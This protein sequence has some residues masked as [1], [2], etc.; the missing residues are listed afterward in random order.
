MMAGGGAN[1]HCKAYVSTKNHFSDMKDPDVSLGRYKRFMPIWTELRAADLVEP[2]KVFLLKD[3]PSY[4]VG[5][6]TT[7]T[8]WW[9]EPWSLINLSQAQVPCASGYGGLW[10]SGNLLYLTSSPGHNEMME[11]SLVD[12]IVRYV[13]NGGNLL[14]SACAGRQYIENQKE[15]WVLLKKFGFAPP[16]GEMM[17]NRPTITTPVKS[18]MFNAESKPFTLRDFWIVKPPEG[19][20]TTAFFEGNQQRA[21]ITWKKFGK[22]K[23]AILWAQTIVPPLFS[24]ENGRYAFLSDVA[25]W[26]GVQPFAE[27][28]DNRLWTNLLKTK[29]GKKF[30]GL[31]HVGSWQNAPSAPVEGYV[32]WLKLPQGKYRVTELISGKELGEWTAD[33]LGKEGISVKMVPKSVAIYRMI[34]I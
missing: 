25:K 1:A 31:V 21:A 24:P 30:Y 4:L 27:V 5:A 22:G 2:V 20:E 29:D 9:G 13:E 10:E 19:A 26:A 18:G 23:V 6:K 16:E 33:K 8:G 11:K 14:M 28:T 17:K 12:R 7:Y 3:Q 15:D 32:H 34:S